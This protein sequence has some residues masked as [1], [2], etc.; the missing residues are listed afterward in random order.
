MLK[1]ETIKDKAPEDVYVELLKPIG[2]VL[3]D[4]YD[5]ASAV[6]SVNFLKEIYDDPQEIGEILY[7]I[8]TQ[9]S[10]DEI[11]ENEYDGELEPKSLIH[12]MIGGPCSGKQYMNPTPSKGS[13]VALDDKLIRY[14]FRK[15]INDEY[16]EKNYFIKYYMFWRDYEDCLDEYKKLNPKKPHTSI[17]KKFNESTL[18]GRFP[19][20]EET[21]H[22]FEHIII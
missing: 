2:V 14:G 6:M 20:S 17:L 7:R 5:Y 3:G 13:I 21:Y 16:S 8:A 11:E 4:G 15:S 19:R 1:Y 18:K 22:H 10:K 12:F 9:R